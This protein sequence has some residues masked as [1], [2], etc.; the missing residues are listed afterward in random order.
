[1]YG[2]ILCT[3]LFKPCGAMSSVRGPQSMY[4]R[5]FGGMEE[6]KKQQQG[7]ASGVRGILRL[8]I[9]ILV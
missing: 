8:R 7:E 3:L 5:G 2:C 4:G 9:P 6:T 1:M